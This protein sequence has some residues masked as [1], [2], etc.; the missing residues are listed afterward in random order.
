[1]NESN[2][3]ASPAED[4]SEQHLATPEMD[5]VAARRQRLLG[6]LPP[7]VA[8]L[9]TDSDLDKI[10]REER[11]TALADQK[12]QALADARSRIRLEARAEIDLI[13]ASQLR[14]DEERRRLAEKVT[15]RVGLPNDGAG[16]RGRNGFRVDGFLY[17]QGQQ[18]TVTRAKF[19]TLREI[20]D[21]AWR[22]EIRFKTLDQNEPGF[23]GLHALVP[24]MEVING[25]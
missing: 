11:A 12:K 25:A 18:Y 15:F 1:M 22:S 21:R 5:A 9:V 2:A 8:A 17:Q 7:E 3:A 4:A 6:D 14:S 19:E 16:H 24:H 13:P 20:H 10:E 23:G